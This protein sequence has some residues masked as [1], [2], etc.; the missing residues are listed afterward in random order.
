MAAAIADIVITEMIAK[1]LAALFFVAAAAT[2]YALLFGG[3]GYGRMRQLQDEINEQK[4]DNAEVREDNEK[5]AKDIRAAKQ[6]PASAEKHLR[7]HYF[8][9]K[10]DI[11]IIPPP[12]AE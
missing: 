11:L 2:C 12:E 9:K 4:R 8:I 6:N 7:E 3:E 1:V 10:G 5:T